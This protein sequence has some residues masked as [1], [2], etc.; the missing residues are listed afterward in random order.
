MTV[1]DSEGGVVPGAE[2]IV[3]K[4]GESYE[5]R[6][7]EGGRTISVPLN[8]TTT[9]TAYVT[10]NAVNYKPYTGTV[11]VSQQ[12]TTVGWYSPTRSATTP[13]RRRAGTATGA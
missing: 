1:A 2:V 7:L 3:W 9:G 5:V 4:E 10:V 6:A 8:A 13:S 11:T 12:A